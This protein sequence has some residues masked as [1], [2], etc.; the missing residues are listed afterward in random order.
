[1]KGLAPRE[2]WR[3][4][5]RGCGTDYRGCAPDC[6]KDIYERTGKWTGPHVLRVLV[7]DAMTALGRLALR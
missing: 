3:F 4:H 6:P 5:A 1:M 2:Y 7:H